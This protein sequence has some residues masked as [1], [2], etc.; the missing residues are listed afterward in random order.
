MAPT[1]TNLVTGASDP[2]GEVIKPEHIMRVLMQDA[3]IAGDPADLR[4]DPL[5]ALLS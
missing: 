2:A 1:T 3:G 4:V 5:L